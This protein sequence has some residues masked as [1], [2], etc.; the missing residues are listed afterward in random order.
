MLPSSR[1]SLQSRLH[2][3]LPLRRPSCRCLAGM[4]PLR[5]ALALTLALSS[6]SRRRPMVTTPAPTPAAPPTTPSRTTT[7]MPTGTAPHRPLPCR[8]LRG[9]GYPQ[10]AYDS[11]G[12]AVYYTGLLPQ[13]PSAVNGGGMS[14]SAAVLGTEPS[15]PVAV[16]TT[17][18]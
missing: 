18:S 8:A 5:L 13:Y 15:K 9:Q 4:D 2:H 3:R 12:R 10:V 7:A 1:R 17:V 11:N 14:T 6:S 16:K